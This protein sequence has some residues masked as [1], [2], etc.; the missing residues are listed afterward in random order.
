MLD[1]D[2]FVL[3]AQELV[4]LY[5]LCHNRLDKVKPKVGVKS[6]D[7]EKVLEAGTIGTVMHDTLYTLQATLKNVGLDKET[8]PTLKRPHFK[9]RKNP[10]AE[11]DNF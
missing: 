4:S 11:F 8:N 7:P 5:L 3:D 6:E 10:F 9:G 1:S 2:G